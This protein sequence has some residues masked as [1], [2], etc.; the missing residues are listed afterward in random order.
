MKRTKEKKNDIDVIVEEYKNFV[1]F[2]K[3]QNEREP[4]S[5]AVEHGLARDANASWW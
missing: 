1:E 2:T 4:M 5:W 3:V